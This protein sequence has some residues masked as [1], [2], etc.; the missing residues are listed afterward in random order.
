MTK[1]FV[2]RINSLLSSAD[3]PLRFGSDN[4]VVIPMAVIDELQNYRG[5]PEKKK[6]AEDI[7]SYLESFDVNQLLNKG[8][9]Q[10][11]G[12]TI[13]IQKNF[14]ETKIDMDGITETDKRVF[15]VCIGLQEKHK[16]K[17][18]ILVSKNK[19]IRIKARALG[20]NA[21]DFLL[22]YDESIIEETTE[23]NGED[24]NQG[25]P[26][27]NEFPGWGIAIIVIVILALLAGVGVFV[28]IKMRK[29][30]QG[31]LQ[32]DLEVAV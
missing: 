20:I 12:S 32:S 13:Q 15:Q 28:F 10:A 9:K 21:E 1:I 11:N 16:D 4:I 18:V 6:I 24:L 14:H 5:K 17:K 30:K 31:T 8:A 22:Q 25:D 27:N 23:I 3:S 19:A 7:L 26:E 29:N 2:L